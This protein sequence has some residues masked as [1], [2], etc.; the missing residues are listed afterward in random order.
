MSRHALLLTGLC[1]FASS[2]A[3]GQTRPLSLEDYYR[4]ET[5]GSPAMS[6]DG[7]RV[8]FVRTYIVEAENQR[9]SEIW[10]APSDGSSPGTRLTHPSFSSS[11]PRWSPDGRLLAFTSQRRVPGDTEP[12]ASVWFLR[13][14]QPGE[15][16]QIPGVE[17]TPVFS[18]DN[19]WIA[20]TK[21]SPPDR[22][23][24][25]APATDF[26]RRLAERF[27]GRTYDWMNYRFD[28]RGYLKDPRD[29]LVTPPEE[30][31]VVPLN[32][33]TPRQLTTLG[34]NVQEIAWRPDSRALVIVA[35]AHQRDEYTYERADLWVVDLTGGVTRLTGDGYDHDG[36]AW[37]PDGRW[38]VFRRQ[39]GLS[40]VIAVGQS[41]GAPV[42]LF[43]MPA[44]GGPMENL[45]GQWD[46]L[47]GSP[48]VGA[49]GRFAYF[50]GGMGGADHL[51]RVSLAGGSVEQ[52]TR[53][54]RRLSGFTFSTDFTRMAYGLTDP[55][56]PAEIY[57][58]RLDGSD[59]RRLS[60]L[61]DALLSEALV[62][63]AGRVS[64]KSADGTDVEGWVI[65]PQVAGNA[66]VPLILA[67]H[68]GPHGA[69]G[70]DFSF[71]FQLWAA[72]G[73]G[74]L[75]TNPRGS[76]GYGERFLWGTWGGWGLKD[77]EDV[78]AGVDHV[79]ARFPV[80]A[81][82]L[83][84]TGYSY[85]GFLTNWLITHSNRFAAA[86][87]GAGISNWVSDYG[88][89]DIPRTKES[90]FFGPPWEE[91]SGRLL[92]D[93]SPV[94]HADAAVTPTM[95]VHGES[96]FRVPIEQAEQMYVALKKRRVPAMFVRYPDMYH[97]N[98]TPWNTVHRYYQ[99]LKWWEKWLGRRSSTE[100]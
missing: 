62:R 69:Y 100:Q 79:V 77:S 85:G 27:T 73:Y 31:Y 21:S 24:A 61:N 47:P 18:P 91:R 80:D 58:A 12:R 51:F 39:M 1:L 67:I 14:D 65:L 64:Y 75:Y 13:M 74:V 28:G 25:P 63:P 4:V 60:G 43:R 34:V 52:V 95:F 98:W 55:T 90:E 30:L 19:Q 6:P 83:A 99:E 59:E 22:G 20:F 38:L 5:A 86:V 35:N 42:D 17:G 33:G 97:G 10:V 3:T 81:E 15:A 88:T 45:T 96:D 40:M 32:G 11:S 36:P 41:H 68:G 72:R 94:M 48:R 66:R 16:F 9:R 92:M 78:L 37:S 87:S 49:D 29:P 26:E 23:A 93:L 44:A 46:L 89:A 82:R 84:V 70:Y 57:S 7:K 2:P 50:G 76:T 71:Q 56:H 54:E 8:A 53:G